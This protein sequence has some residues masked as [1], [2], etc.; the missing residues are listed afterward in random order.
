MKTRGSAST[1]GFASAAPHDLSS[2]RRESPA[3]KNL[4]NVADTGAWDAWCCCQE[5][6]GSELEWQQYGSPKTMVSN[7][8]SGLWPERSPIK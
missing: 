8:L 1:L 3:R 7:Y 5:N 6:H 2:N 4:R